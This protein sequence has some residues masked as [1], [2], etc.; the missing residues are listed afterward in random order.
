MLK[1]NFK[2]DKYVI[3]ST[4]FFI[5]DFYFLKHKPTIQNN[6]T[7]KAYLLIGNTSSTCDNK[8]NNRW[9]H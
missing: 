8:T 2:L 4:K 6:T 3:P 7:H 1:K 9:F 5:N